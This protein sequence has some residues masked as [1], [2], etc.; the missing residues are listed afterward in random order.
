MSV[1][2]EDIWTGMKRMSQR[3]RAV[4]GNGHFLMPTMVFVLFVYLAQQVV[5]INPQISMYFSLPL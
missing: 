4:G 3:D 1:L 2:P 5:E